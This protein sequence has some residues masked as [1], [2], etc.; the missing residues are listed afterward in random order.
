[1]IRLCALLAVSLS[2]AGCGAI[3][4]ATLTAG[5]GLAGQAIGVGEQIE[6]VAKDTWIDLHPPKAP[7][8]CV[9]P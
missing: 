1:M 2:L 4:M 9:P 5:I 6:T 7:T 3:G 8:V